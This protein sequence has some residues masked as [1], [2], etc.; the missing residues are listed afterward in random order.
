[1]RILFI[2]FATALLVVLV[3]LA[4]RLRTL[5][6]PPVSS[7]ESG[8][9]AWYINATLGDDKNSGR[10]E[11]AAWK[12][13]GRLLQAPLLPGDT[14]L[15]H[16]GDIWRESLHINSSGENAAPI[17]VTAYGEGDAPSLRGSDSYSSPGQWRYEREGLWYIDDLR[18]DP[19]MVIRDGQ[20]AKCRASKDELADP[21]DFWYDGTT[22]RLYVRLDTNPAAVAE[23]IEIPV[24]EF[25]VGPLGTSY[26]QITDLD[27]RHPR[28]T[29]LLIWEG[30][31]VTLE[32]CAF[33]QSPG[34]HLQIGQGSNYARVLGCEFDDWAAAL[35]AS[36]AIQ[37]IESGSGPSDVENCSFTASHPGSGGGHTAIRSEDKA[38]IRLVRSCRFTGNGGNLSGDGVSLSRPNGAASTITMEDNTFGSLGGCAIALDGLDQYGGN[39]SVTIQRNRIQDVCRGDY[40]ERDGIRVLG[41]KSGE[42]TLVIAANL[43]QGTAAGT[44]PHAGILVQ[45][46][47][48]ARIL[49]NGISGTDDGIVVGFGSSAT[50]IANTVV[51]GNRG[52]GI[53]DE[54]GGA[55]STHNVFYH[56]GGGDVVGVALGSDDST[57]NPLLDAE[58][59]PQ[60]GSPCIDRGLEVGLAIDLDG[61]RVPSGTGP[62][63][64]PYELSP[65]VP[66]R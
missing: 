42:T 2:L 35:P 55:Q 49:H 64:G 26:L 44:H 8:P 11:A 17:T 25:V 27:L 13:L 15:L 43:I 59:R 39:L 62:D 52:A 9:R 19:G 6:P 7:S 58:L 57:T 40:V 38:W 65:P 4:T 21:W 36:Y 54:S 56:N 37:A 3:I 28:K 32:R 60:S 31:H 30:D 53:R 51:T 10:S 20:L 1:M 29:T 22:R 24:R 66:K 16:R 12:T 46:T 48:G 23:Q 14:V 33:R 41:L 47:R 45:E 50:L 61:K 5:P 34:T 63:I 18:D